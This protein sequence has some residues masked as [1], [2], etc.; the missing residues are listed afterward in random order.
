M[1]QSI[2]G[3]MPSPASRLTGLFAGANPNG[4]AAPGAGQPSLPNRL[5]PGLAQ[6]MANSMGPAPGMPASL[7]AQGPNAGAMAQFSTNRGGFGAPANFMPQQGA[8]NAASAAGP[9]TGP[10]PTEAPSA[11]YMG[12]PNA[13]PTPT[14]LKSGVQEGSYA[15]LQGI[16]AN[17]MP[18][19]G[20]AASSSGSTNATASTAG[21]SSAF[22][23]AAYLKA[24][25][26]VAKDPYFA[27]NPQAH[28]N[29][30]GKNEGR[31]PTGQSAATTTAD[32]A[33]Q[34]YQYQTSLDWGMKPED[35]KRIIDEQAASAMNVQAGASAAPNGGSSHSTPAQTSTSST[36]A[37]AGG[38][39]M[40]GIEEMLANWARGGG[41]GQIAPGY[42]FRLSDGRDFGSILRRN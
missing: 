7:G 36:S 8:S 6:P 4:F 18:Q 22:D 13:L 25:P 28:Y 38:Q 20:A 35:I 21:T 17:G 10:M 9:R 16:L 32:P 2:W 41:Q 5:P 11:S 42:S 3:N 37:G 33:K 29:A 39:S 24:Y 14:G 15:R 12:G 27:Q 40:M 30:F 31:N 26:D 1:T 19:Q 23:G 34:K